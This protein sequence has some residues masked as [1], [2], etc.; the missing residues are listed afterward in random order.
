MQDLGLYLTKHNALIFSDFH[1]GFEETLNT[2][3]SLVP[4]F[5]FK[6]TITRLDRICANIQQPI[7]TIILNGDIKHEF[8]TI[9]TQEWREILKLIDFLLTRCKK[10]VIVKGNHDVILNIIAK[11]RNIDIVKSVRMGNILIAHGDSIDKGA[12][13]KTVKTIIIGHDHPAFA[14]RE[15]RRVELF[16][17][18]LKGR[19]KHKT[20]IVQPSF[21]T[22]REGTDVLQGRFLSPYLNQ[23]TDNFEIFLVADKVRY[24]GRVKD[25]Q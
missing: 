14:V 25:N 9:T 20:L 10:V 18:Y 5:Q 22:V 16:K 3:G 17:C 4:R 1:L 23:K 8:G 15:N 12:L 19:W 21:N 24:F 13:E 6:D 11:K 2:R 7:E